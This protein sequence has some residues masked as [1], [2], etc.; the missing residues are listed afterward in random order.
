[1]HN[2]WKDAFASGIGPRS[3]REAFMLFIKGMAVGTADLIP[4][5]SGGTVA[6]LTGIY[7]NVIKSITSVNKDFLKKIF[8]GHIK[9]AVD[10]LPT[11][12]LFPLGMG[13]LTAL[14]VLVH[15]L[16]YFLEHHQTSV[17]SLFFGLILASILILIREQKELFSPKPLGT[18][19]LGAL[20]ASFFLSNISPVALPDHH[21]VLFV[22]G[23]LAA[24]ALILPGPSGSFLLLVFGQYER[25]TKAL[26]NPFMQEN[27]LVLLILMSGIFFG[28]ISS[29]RLLQKLL[30]THRTLLVAFITGLLLGSLKKIWPW[31]E[32]VEV[33]II[34]GKTHVLKEAGHL[35]DALDQTTL[36]AVVLMVGGGG[37]VILL[38]AYKR[39]KEY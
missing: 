17:W 26:S 24:W 21:G 20:L 12:F 27:F 32:A 1:M 30:K 22:C 39:R 14:L 6:F 13:M 23:I 11:R 9:D 19:L 37:L 18:L 5:I 31:K 15:P 3:A 28:L 33:Q 2:S 16:R 36:V 38:D 25:M 7:E 35:P 4:G 8:T 34:R 10:H 29:S